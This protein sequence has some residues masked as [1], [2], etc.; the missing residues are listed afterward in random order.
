MQEALWC[1]QEA[2]RADQVGSALL[3]IRDNIGLDFYEATT[4]LLREVESSSR[5]LRDLYDLFPIYRPQVPTVSQ[6]LAVILPS[7]QKILKDMII[8]LDHENLPALDKWNTMNERLGGQ[9]GMNLT[10]CFV[11]YIEYLVQNIR[12]LSR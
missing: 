2:R 11:L 3:R 6:H 8:Y 12:L 9:D 5:L 1:W 7:F 4:A 10:Q